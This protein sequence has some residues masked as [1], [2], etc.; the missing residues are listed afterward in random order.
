M[1]TAETP[2][3]LAHLSALYSNWLNENTFWNEAY[4]NDGIVIETPFQYPDTDHIVLYLKKLDSGWT[5]TDGAETLNRWVDHGYDVSHT[6]TCKVIDATLAGF[7]A[8]RTADCELV[9]QVADEKDIPAAITNLSQAI[10]V[11]SHV[12]A[13]LRQIL[14]VFSTWEPKK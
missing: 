13:Y 3:Q 2:A 6:K 8:Q 9:I 1:A 11:L 5:L 4:G 12:P 10:I 7:G 14:R